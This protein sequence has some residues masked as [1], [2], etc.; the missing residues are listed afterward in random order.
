MTDTP[1]NK[2]ASQ[3]LKVLIDPKGNKAATNLFDTYIHRGSG[4]YTRHPEFMLALDRMI[5]EF[6]GKAL[7]P[8]EEPVPGSRPTVKDEGDKDIH[9]GASFDEVSSIKSVIAKLLKG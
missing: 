7:P 2:H 8:E 4:D 3:Q 9:E 6:G 5:S 1:E